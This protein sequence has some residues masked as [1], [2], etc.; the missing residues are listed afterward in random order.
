[1]DWGPPAGPGQENKADAA[2][3]A[4]GDRSGAACRP[5]GGSEGRQDRTASMQEPK[6]AAARTRTR[7]AIGAL[8]IAAVFGIGIPL[9]RW[10]Q[11]EA[12]VLSRTIV[13]A[14]PWVYA[15][16]LAIAHHR[17]APRWWTPL[18]MIAAWG[19][20]TVAVIGVIESYLGGSTQ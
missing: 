16:C 7:V 9:H 6:Q 19:M 2:K 1:M 20:A 8:M 14:G 12:Q 18:A 4:T 5:T 3:K 11:S 13:F 10:I 15:G 17:A